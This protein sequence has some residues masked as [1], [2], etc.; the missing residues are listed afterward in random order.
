[1]LRGD[2]AS[3]PCPRWLDE[4]VAELENS[5]VILGAVRGNRLPWRQDWSKQANAWKQYLIFAVTWMVL[6]FLF[7]AFGN[8]LGVFY[9]VLA[10]GFA[11]FSRYT[12]RASRRRPGLGDSVR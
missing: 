2:L 1:M 12:Y 4:L 11:M 9:L 7:L 10:A 5:T 3:V 6:G 8:W